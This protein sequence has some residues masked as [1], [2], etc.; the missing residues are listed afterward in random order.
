M[1]LHSN[2]KLKTPEITAIVVKVGAMREKEQQDVLIDLW[3]HFLLRAVTT[4][5]IA[6]SQ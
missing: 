3:V 2:V 6:C 4:I 5:E 1:S